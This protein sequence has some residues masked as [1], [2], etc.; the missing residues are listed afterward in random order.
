MDIEDIPERYGGKLQTDPRMAPNLDK[1]L[2]DVLQWAPSSE[3]SLPPGPLHW[4]NG[5]DGSKTAVAI[6]A[7][8]GENRR[9]EFATIR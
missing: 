9:V 4:V 5:H 3:K 1:K 7:V 2:S 6:G 8:N